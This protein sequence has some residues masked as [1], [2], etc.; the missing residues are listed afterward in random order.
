MPKFTDRYLKKPLVSRVQLKTFHLH[1]WLKVFPDFLGTRSL[2]TVT[3]KEV[4]ARWVSA[5]STSS[6][7]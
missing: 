4:M 5:S 7:Q 2:S 1:I 3:R 6:Q